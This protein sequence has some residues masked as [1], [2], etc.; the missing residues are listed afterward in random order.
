MEQLQCTPR[1]SKVSI[2][3]DNCVVRRTHRKLQ[4]GF[5]GSDFEELSHLE[6][7]MQYLQYHMIKKKS[8]HLANRITF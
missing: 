4:C 3:I 7:H 6:N 5:C 2:N 8:K 1:T